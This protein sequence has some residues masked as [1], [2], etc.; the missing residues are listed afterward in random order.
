MIVDAYGGVIPI[1]QQT[2]AY[3]TKVAQAAMHQKSIV[4]YAPQ[5]KAA[6]AYIQVAEEI[7]ANEQ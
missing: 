4:E 7:I 2:I 6:Q 1:F 3:S 5:H